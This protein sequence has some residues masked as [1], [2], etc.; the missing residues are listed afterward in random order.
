VLALPRWRQLGPLHLDHAAGQPCRGIAIFDPLQP[1]DQ[2]VALRLPFDQLTRY[3][4]P[5]AA[6]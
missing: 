2:P 1:R 4:I 6:A 3:A 5:R